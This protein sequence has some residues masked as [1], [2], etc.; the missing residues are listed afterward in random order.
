[1]KIRLHARSAG[2][3]IHLRAGCEASEALFQLM[4]MGPRNTIFP[5]E[6]PLLV[7]MGFEPEFSGDLRDMKREVNNK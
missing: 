5:S 7:K 2:G 6:I 3:R 4:S 1:M